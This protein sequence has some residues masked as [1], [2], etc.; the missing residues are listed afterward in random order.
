MRDLILPALR[1]SVVGALATAIHILVFL[2]FVEVVGAGPTFSTMPA[3]LC[4]VVFSYALN[5]SWTFRAR[6]GHRRFF[7]RY[8][9]VAVVGVGLNVTIMHVCT[10]ILAKSYFVGLF[11]SV[12]IVPA[13]NFLGNRYW[14]FR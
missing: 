6:G 12:L 5:H 2:L 4:A 3:F 7:V 10:S 8:L 13:F 14:G 1:F 9:L 11:F